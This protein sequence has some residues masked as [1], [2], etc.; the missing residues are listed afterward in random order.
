V[1]LPRVAASALLADPATA[2]FAPG[3]DAGAWSAA[4]LC[5]RVVARL[6]AS[7]ASWH[8]WHMAFVAAA[9]RGRYTEMVSAMSRASLEPVIIEDLVKFGID[10]G[11]AKGVDQ[12]FAR[13]VAEGGLA[14]ARDALLDAL[15]ARGFAVD[16]ALRARVAGEGSLEQLRTWLRRAVTA[17]ALAQVFDG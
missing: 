10:Q 15:S 12:G 5:D 8:Q 17:D 13:G 11:F 14:V 9:V 16:A 6:A 1:L 3:A 4:E 2:C 7:G